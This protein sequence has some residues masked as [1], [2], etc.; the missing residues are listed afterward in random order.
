MS[1]QLQH[2][3]LLGTLCTVRLLQRQP[4][5]QSG[6]IGHRWLAGNHP[7]GSILTYPMTMRTRYRPQQPGACREGP[8]PPKAGAQL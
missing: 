4:L 7:N 3:C 1:Q 8:A 5:P 2:A 6:V